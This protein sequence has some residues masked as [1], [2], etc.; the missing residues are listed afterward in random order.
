MIC[1]GQLRSWHAFPQVQSAM[2]RAV[3]L[4]M[5]TFVRCAA[6]HAKCENCES[7]EA[8]TT[9]QLTALNSL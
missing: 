9:S 1:F 7:T 8:A 2:P 5:Y 4:A 6:Y 3:P